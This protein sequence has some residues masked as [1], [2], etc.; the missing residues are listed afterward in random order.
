MSEVIVSPY[1]QPGE[2]EPPPPKKR[3]HDLLFALGFV[4]VFFVG[5]PGILLFGQSC[6]RQRKANQ[7]SIEQA[8][9]AFKVVRY[10]DNGIAKVQAYL[11]FRNEAEQ[12]LDQLSGCKEKIK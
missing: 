12:Y 4:L 5:F 7:C 6:D 11:T 2:K 10:D 9:N 3:N 1:R 8:D